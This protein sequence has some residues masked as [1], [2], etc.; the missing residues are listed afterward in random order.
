MYDELH[1]ASGTI[2]VAAATENA[3]DLSGSLTLADDSGQT[4]TVAEMTVHV[5]SR[6][7]RDGLPLRVFLASTGTRPSLST[8]VAS[9]RA[10]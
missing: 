1:V 5:A 10:R 8:S 3:L 4:F 2:N 9:D 7:R 6:L